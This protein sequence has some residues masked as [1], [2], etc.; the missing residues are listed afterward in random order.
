[1]T[2][3]TKGLPWEGLRGHDEG[4]KPAKAGCLDCRIEEKKDREREG[5]GRKEEK[6]EGDWLT[7]SYAL[8]GHKK[9]MLGCW[10][11]PF[12]CKRERERER[13]RGACLPSEKICEKV[14]ENLVH[15][16]NHAQIFSNSSMLLYSLVYTLF[17]YF[18]LVW[19]AGGCRKSAGKPLFPA[20]LS[21]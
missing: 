4:E 6:E 13:E 20:R 16:S 11:E 17:Q 21:F 2:F 19:L 3:G 1:M 12:S 8:V 15:S 9:Y 14:K 10:R 5:R 7:L 18:M